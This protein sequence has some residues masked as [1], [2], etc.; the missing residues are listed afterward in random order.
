MEAGKGYGKPHPTTA[1][2]Y[3]VGGIDLGPALMHYSTPSAPMKPGLYIA[4]GYFAGSIDY[5]YVE[6]TAAVTINPVADKSPPKTQSPPSGWWVSVTPEVFSGVEGQSLND[7]ALI[8]DGNPF[9]NSGETY[10]LSIDWGDGMGLGEGARIDNTWMVSKPYPYSEE[11]TY[12]IK[13]TATVTGA[14]ASATFSI[15]IA[16]AGITESPSDDPQPWLGLD[17]RVDG[18]LGAIVV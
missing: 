8:A 14:S 13:I 1:E 16:D 17:G 12:T 6:G 7:V 11:G 15:T 18:R 3:G 2:S 4:Y 10:S 9:N 5:D